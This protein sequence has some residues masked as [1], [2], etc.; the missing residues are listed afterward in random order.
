MFKPVIQSVGIIL[1]PAKQ[2]RASKLQDVQIAGKKAAPTDKEEAPL[3]FVE[4]NPE[5]PGGYEAMLRYLHDKLQYPSTAQEARIT[6]TVFVS[7]VVSKTGKISNTRILRG[8]GNA[9]DE[10]AIKVVDGMPDWIP[11]RQ[12]GRAVPVIFQ[13]PIK[14]QLQTN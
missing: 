13:I 9:C 6:G 7:F 3:L 8:I 1:E 2:N 11:A 14:F 10:E 12:N 4:Q 5:Y